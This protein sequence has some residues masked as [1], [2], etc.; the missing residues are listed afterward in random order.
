MPTLKIKN[1][2]TGK[3]EKLPT[4]KGEDGLTPYIK[5]GYWYVGEKNTDVRAEAKDGEDYILTNAD[6]EEI[7]NITEPLVETA[8]QPILDE[9]QEISEK[10]ETIAK[11][12]ATGYVFDTLEDLELWLQNSENTSKLVLGDNLYIRAVGVPDYWW[13]GTEKQVLETQKV[14]LS[15]YAKNTDYA[16]GAKAG[17]VRPAGGLY[18][19]GSNKDALLIARASNA[20]IDART[21][22][23]YPIVSSNLEYAVKSVLKDITE[24]WTFTLEDGTTVTK[25]VVLL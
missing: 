5:D 14:D 3:W 16:T 1:Q 21:D 15:E 6:K 11:G 7:A 10:A 25:K 19:S 9:I 23:N 20:Q 8:I 2:K 22:N 24:E 4:V 13:D 18:M 17:L 12:R